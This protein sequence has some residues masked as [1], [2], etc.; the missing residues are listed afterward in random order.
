MGDDMH[1][2]L[3]VM[4]GSGKIR[5]VRET[6]ARS[7]ENTHGLRNLCALP[8]KYA[9]AVSLRTR[10]ETYA[11][12]CKN[13]HGPRNLRALRQKYARPKKIPQNPTPQLHKKARQKN[14]PCAK[15]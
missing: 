11:R 2:A 7:R 13:T 6:Y 3:R 14:L 4:R 9:R 5:A 12:S 8:A 15:S 10:R 1:D